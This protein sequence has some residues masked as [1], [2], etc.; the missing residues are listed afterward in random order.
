MPVVR[1]IVRESD[2]YRLKNLILGIVQSEPFRM[3]SKALSDAR[4]A[5]DRAT[6]NNRDSRRVQ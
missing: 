2:G 3:R 1:R 6:P 4:V 5:A